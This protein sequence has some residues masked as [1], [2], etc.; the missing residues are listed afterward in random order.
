M[1]RRLALLLGAAMLTVSL[2]GCSGGGEIPAVLTA[3]ILPAKLQA[4]VRLADQRQPATKN[5]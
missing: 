2:A 4:A 5:L 1:K 3:G